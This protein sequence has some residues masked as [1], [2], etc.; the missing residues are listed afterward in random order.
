MD[1]R[2]AVELIAQ[3][4][5][6]ADMQAKFAAAKSTGKRKRGKHKAKLLGSH[7]PQIHTSRD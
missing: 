5:K 3:R 2:T 6:F 1:Y 4:V 7:S